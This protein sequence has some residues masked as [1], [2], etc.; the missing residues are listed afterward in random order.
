MADT[1]VDTTT[2]AEVTA[3]V[4]FI[5]GIFFFLCRVKKITITFKSLGFLG[6][7]FRVK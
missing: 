4:C 7:V 3:K 5:Q 1:A 6:R 2:T